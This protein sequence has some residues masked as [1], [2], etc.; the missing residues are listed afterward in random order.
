MDPN[1]RVLE[2]SEKF[3]QDKVY[4]IIR[5]AVEEIRVDIDDADSNKG[6]V[7]GFLKGNK[8]QPFNVTF[9]LDPKSN[10]IGVKIEHKLALR[11]IERRDLRDLSEDKYEER[12]IVKFW[13]YVYG[14]FGLGEAEGFGEKSRISV[15]DSK[16]KIK[17]DE[18]FKK[19]LMNVFNSDS[20]L[21]RIVKGYNVEQENIQQNYK[22]AFKSIN[23]KSQ[24]PLT[25]I[26]AV[27][28]Y[29]NEEK[30]N[31]VTIAINSVDMRTFT[32][33]PTQVMFVMKIPKPLIRPLD[34]S[35]KCQWTSPIFDD[36]S[37]KILSYLNFEISA[38]EQR[39]K[40][41]FSDS[42]MYNFKFEEV[43][44]EKGKKSKIKH[45]QTL[46]NP[47][48]IIPIDNPLT[49]SQE[50]VFAMK[51]F[52]KFGK[53]GE[54]EG[55]L[56]IYNT[57]ILMSDLFK[58]LKRYI[59]TTPEEVEQK[60]L[61]EVQKIQQ[62]KQE[63]ESQTLSRCIKCGWL[64]SKG[65]S[66]CPMCGSEIVN[67]EKKSMGVESSFYSASSALHGAKENMYSNKL[68]DQF[69]K[70]IEEWGDGESKR[71]N[72]V[73]NNFKE[74]LGEANVR[75]SI[76]QI[77]KNEEKIKEIIGPVFRGNKIA[78]SREVVTIGRFLI[79]LTGFDI[80]WIYVVFDRLKMTRDEIFPV[81]VSYIITV[82][83]NPHKYSYVKHFDSKN[84][85]LVWEIDSGMD[86]DII[87]TLNF[88]SQDFG[89]VLK[90]AYNEG[91]TTEF[92]EPMFDAKGKQRGVELSIE[93]YPL[94]RVEPFLDDKSNPRSIIIMR[95]FLDN[96]FGGLKGFIPIGNI[97]AIVETLGGI[98][99]IFKQE[100]GRVDPNTPEEDKPIAV[101][102][103]EIDR[104]LAES[105]YAGKKNIQAQQ[106]SVPNA[107]Q[108]F[109]AGIQNS[110]ESSSS[111]SSANLKSGSTDDNFDQQFNDLF[112]KTTNLETEQKTKYEIIDVRN[113]TFFFKQLPRD[114]IIDP[115]LSDVQIDS[116]IF[117][118]NS[119]IHTLRQL[120]DTEFNS[121]RSGNQSFDMCQNQTN[122]MMNQIREKQ[123]KIRAYEFEK[124]RVKPERVSM[125]R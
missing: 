5:N 72:I 12:I 24:W 14:S 2:P 100:Y 33:V 51:Y 125:K 86:P 123:A 99:S 60:R 90:N 67:S 107:G 112:G 119:E 42:S 120:L 57:I 74:A 85:E 48:N 61:L 66:K 40:S 39:L 9:Q 105:K 94:I 3:T 65:S 22:W 26:F 114:F 101:D 68:I 118:L 91:S 108:K 109:I 49:E 124:F 122:A 106:P 19:M 6:Y 25:T 46:L 10:K 37:Q 53:T 7:K 4:K 64:L 13:D 73:F 69:D 21:K 35:Y 56:S 47:I 41:M 36:E 88:K 18:Y 44:D 63:A 20:E 29:L 104:K 75:D 84:K 62:K 59:V 55:I 8:R 79:E 17:L 110:L 31:S 32:I 95:H 103:S 81:V 83:Y 113:K 54:Y 117:Q 116:T 38:I 111:S 98:I 43:I 115:L 76:T 45:D 16:V 58:I 89:K 70:A 27:E 102:F 96:E 71:I 93:L 78:W 97:F 28:L 30:T 82:P 11:E 87:T 34:M 77:L 15:E 1:T 52:L 92:I 50:Y 23:Q 121:Y 80:P